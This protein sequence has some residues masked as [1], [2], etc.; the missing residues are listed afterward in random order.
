MV[1]QPVVRVAVGFGLALAAVAAGPT[2]AAAQGSAV[3]V[4]LSRKPDAARRDAAWKAIAEAPALERAG[5]SDLADALAGE[6]R[7]G[8]EKRGR[9]AAA[10]AATLAAKGQCKDA[11]AAARAAVLELAAAQAL[12]AEVIAD[13]SKA[14]AAQLI[15]ALADGDRPEAY[16]RAMS[17]RALGQQAPPDGVSAADWAQFPELDAEANVPLAELVIDSKVPGATVWLDFVEVGPARATV[18]VARGAHVIAAADGSA[19]AASAIELSGWSQAEIL[20]PARSGRWAAVDAL[21][22]QIRAG[23]RRATAETIYEIMKITGAGYLVLLLDGGISESWARSGTEAQMLGR[24]RDDGQ[25]VAMASKAARPARS[26]DP[27]RELLRETELERRVREAGQ[28]DRQKT[29]WWVYAAVIG[30]A[31]VGAGIIIVGDSGD[32]RQ[33]FEIALP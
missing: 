10:S 24:R 29:K 27:D 31:V 8:S 11:R 20:A 30:A 18:H 17:L 14:R 15:C 7:P 33:R 28:A 32:D 1:A 21:I 2:P 5:D 13:V 4:D 12:G 22:D 26:P 23:E 25:S 3:V 9:E 16:S 6:L 19:V